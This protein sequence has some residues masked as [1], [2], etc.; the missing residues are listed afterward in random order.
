MSLNVFLS[1]APQQGLSNTALVHALKTALSENEEIKELMRLPTIHED[2][3]AAIPIIKSLPPVLSSL[4][5]KTFN[6]YTASVISHDRD[7]LYRAAVVSHYYPNSTLPL[8]STAASSPSSSSSTASV[9]SRTVK[10]SNGKVA[11]MVSGLLGS[12]EQVLAAHIHPQSSPIDTLNYAGLTRAEV[13]SVRNGLLLGVGIEKAFDRLD[14]S[15]VPLS[16]VTPNRF[17]MRIWTPNGL[18]TS[19]IKKTYHPGDVRLLPLWKSKRNPRRIGRFEGS[20]LVYGAVDKLPL[21]RALSY[22]AWLAYDRA[23]KL[24]W[25]DMS[26]DP[27]P[28]FGTPN[29]SPFQIQREMSA[30]LSSMA[31]SEEEED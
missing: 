5:H 10:D 29:S 9:T 15:F 26:T 31:L 7:P 25:V 1:R 20:E 22:Q 27:P 3:A 6:P 21:R 12:H 4:A 18:A 2:L 23:V 19:G 13:D 8:L 24:G 30:S 16:P 28:D 17:I 14:I 11:C